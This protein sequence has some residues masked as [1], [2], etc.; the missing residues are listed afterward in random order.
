MAE[1]GIAAIAL[2]HIINHRSVTKAGVTLSIYAHN[3][4]VGEK[5][6]A[7]DLRSRRIDALGRGGAKIVPIRKA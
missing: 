6:E 4:Y 1:L 5:A 2:G 7:L 3:D